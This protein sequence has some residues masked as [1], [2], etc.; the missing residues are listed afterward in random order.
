MSALSFRY[1]WL[2]FNLFQGDDSPVNGPPLVPKSG[3]NL[4][5]IHESPPETHYLSR[6]GWVWS[7]IR[8]FVT[9][10]EQS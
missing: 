6:R 10:S 7:G 5:Y 4:S 1:V 8:F 9:I 3:Q 2:G